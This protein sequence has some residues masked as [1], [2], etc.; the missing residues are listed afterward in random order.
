MIDQSTVKQIKKAPVEERIQIIKAILESLKD[1][2]N[3]QLQ[4]R[5][6]RFKHFKIRKFSLGNEVH[7][8]RDEL[9]F[10]RGL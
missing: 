8:D 2:I 7:V 10:K 1:D 4:N 6:L 3:P 9:Y 5:E